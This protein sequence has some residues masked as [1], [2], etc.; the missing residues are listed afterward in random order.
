[1]KRILLI[2]L[3]AAFALSA[4]G[5]SPSGGENYEYKG[6]VTEVYEN[7]RGETVIVTVSD[8]VES[9]FVIKS[10]T[11]MIAPGETA[12]AV[13]DCVQL[14]T[15]R[16]SDADIKKMKVSPAYSTSGRLLYVE[17]EDSPFILTENADGTRSF[18]RLI[19]EKSTLPGI[20]GMG[21]VIKV[22][23]SSPVLTD[24]P[25]A[26]VE[27]LIFIE[28]GTAE[29]ITDEDRAFIVSQGYTVISE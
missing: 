27:A 7:A 4:V 10:N 6:F 23:H 29:D 28:N 18:V 16:S 9:E 14:T 8:D 19:D 11:E 1:M 26:A 13:G 25:T 17:G 21:D 2:V 22:Y 3:A 5:C 24:D 15:L 20:S 12:V